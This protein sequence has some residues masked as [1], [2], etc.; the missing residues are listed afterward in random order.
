MKDIKLI[1]H[2]SYITALILQEVGKQVKPGVTALELDELAE[3]LTKKY[4]CKPAFKGYREFPNS[5]CASINDEVIHGI[6]SNRILKEGDIVGIDFGVIYKGFYGD[7]AIT[8]KVGKILE[9]T[10]TLLDITKQSLMKGIEQA[11]NGN[12][13]GDIS[14]AIQN[15]AE[16]HGY[17]VVRKFSGHGVGKQLQQPPAIPNFGEQNTGEILKNGMTIAI[18]PMIN[19]GNYDVKISEKDGW[20]VFTVDGK[21]SAHFEHTVL[22]RD[23]KP[24]ILTKI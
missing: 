22:I 7:S 12:Q 1:K 9:S 18:E 2:A 19:E 20:T 5:I 24:Q 15:Y 6:P 13:V 21:L 11:V 8:F 4:K 3:K 17:S 23:N 10:Q 14:F 16:K